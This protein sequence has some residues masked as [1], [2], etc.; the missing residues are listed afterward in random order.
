MKFEY[1]DLYE[2]QFENLVIAVC[3]KILGIGVKGF[4]KGPDGGIV[5]SGQIF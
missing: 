3:Q 2:E 5:M 1:V 4:A